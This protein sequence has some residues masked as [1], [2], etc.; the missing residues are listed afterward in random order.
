MKDLKLIEWAN[1]GYPP[2]DLNKQSGAVFHL[3]DE[4]KRLRELVE[5]VYVITKGEKAN[6]LW[7]DIYFDNPQQASVYLK[8]R[9]SKIEEVSL[10]SFITDRGVQY[11]IMS[12]KSYTNLQN[13][14]AEE[15]KGKTIIE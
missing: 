10:Y 12:L 11:T 2:I 13:Q 1:D 5:R 4:I 6:I 9:I 14:V 15:S 8:N 7:N 3:I